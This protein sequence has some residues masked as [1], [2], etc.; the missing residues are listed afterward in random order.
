[1]FD[2]ALGDPPS[3]GP[4]DDVLGPPKLAGP[5]VGAVGRMLPGD[6]V[7]F[8]VGLGEPGLVVKLVG[9]PDPPMGEALPVGEA[10]LG[11]SVLLGP[12]DVGGAG[13]RMVLL[14]GEPPNGC[15][16][17]GLLDDGLKYGAGPFSGR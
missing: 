16:P 12:P 17:L 6:S 9:N 3:V 2:S 8:G 13:G 10:P 7:E 15:E 4:S 14:L 1:M 11:L 5:V